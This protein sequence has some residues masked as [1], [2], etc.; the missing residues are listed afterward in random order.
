MNLDYIYI[1]KLKDGDAAMRRV[2]GTYI[3]QCSCHGSSADIVLVSELKPGDV[4]LL[5]TPDPNVTSM[6]D[7]EWTVI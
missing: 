5:R 6:Y 2:P 4:V 1:M 7:W 3:G